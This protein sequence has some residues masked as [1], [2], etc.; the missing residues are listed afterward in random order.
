[1][2]TDVVTVCPDMPVRELAR[3][4][5]KPRIATR[6]CARRGRTT[7]GR[8]GLGVGGVRSGGHRVYEVP[9]K[10]ERQRGSCGGPSPRAAAAPHR[11]SAPRHIGAPIRFNEFKILRCSARSTYAWHP[12]CCRLCSE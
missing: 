9:W 7:R 4:L 11:V 6:S 12:R 2:T 8:A 1:M 5:L 3:L 10:T